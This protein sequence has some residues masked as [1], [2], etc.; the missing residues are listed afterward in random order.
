M[1]HPLKAPQALDREFP[2]LR[3]R[4][5]ELAATLDRLDRSEG[6]VVDDP[7]MRKIREALDV[8]DRAD[9][10]RA[11]R[12]QHVFSLDYVPDWRQQF[13]LDRRF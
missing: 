4:I 11:E 1:S 10:D 12:V 5:L 8:L 7:R 9:P 2:A 3:A 13:Q 6:D